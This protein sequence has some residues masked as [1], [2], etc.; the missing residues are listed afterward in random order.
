MTRP[1]RAIA[2][3]V[4]AACLCGF[5]LPPAPQPTPQ[6]QPL[7]AQTLKVTTSNGP[8]AVMGYLRLLVIEEL[9]R[10]DVRPSLSIDLFFDVG[11]VN[12][13]QQQLVRLT[14]LVRSKDG[15]TLGTIVQSNTVPAIVLSM[16]HQTWVD[17]AA[18]AAQGIARL[19]KLAMQG[20]EL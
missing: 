8:P 18:G 2:L 4:G 6:A 14:W 9:R 5:L 10:L 17:A 3:I 1:Q 7:A 13:D 15:R 11:P 16:Q 12:E 19:V 20:Q